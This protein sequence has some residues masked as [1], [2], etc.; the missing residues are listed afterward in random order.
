[1]AKALAL[2]VT[3]RTI[4]GRVLDS[5]PKNDK[6]LLRDVVSAALCEIWFYERA[7]KPGVRIDP[8]DVEIFEDSELISFGYPYSAV[9]EEIKKRLPTS[10]ISVATLRVH[11]ANIR[12]SSPGY[13]AAGKLPDKRPYSNKGQKSQ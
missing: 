9:L 8:A 12:D 11:V 3:H 5:K 4:Q 10:K 2:L 1:M 7:E 13:V 6:Q